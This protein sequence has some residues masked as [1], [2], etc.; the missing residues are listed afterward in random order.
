MD[1]GDGHEKTAEPLRFPEDSAGPAAV[2]LWS[3]RIAPMCPFVSTGRGMPLRRI[4]TKLWP[5][6]A[7]RLLLIVCL[8]APVV[9]SGQTRQKGP[10]PYWFDLP[11]SGGEETLD[12]L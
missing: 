7:P 8:A 10:G 11:V 9:L 6:R 12:R 4:A 3:R 2:L 5:V 1:A